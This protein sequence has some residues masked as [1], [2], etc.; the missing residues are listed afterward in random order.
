MKPT[1]Y[2]SLISAIDIDKLPETLRKGHD[3]VIKSTQNL[4]NWT[5]YEQKPA[6][7][8]TIDLYFNKLKQ[9]LKDHKEIT[10]TKTP[11]KSNGSNTNNVFKLLSEIA[12]GLSGYLKKLKKSET[13]AG[14][15]DEQILVHIIFEPLKRA[16]YYAISLREDGE[17]GDDLAVMYDIELNLTTKKVLIDA[18]EHGESVSRNY[19]AG[20]IEKWLQHLIARGLLIDL[21]DSKKS[22]SGRKSSKAPTIEKQNSTQSKKVEHITEEIKFIKRFIGLH[23]KVKSPAN[24][25]SFLKSLQ[26][27]IIQRQIRKTSVFADEIQMIQDKLV[28]AYNGAKG[29][30]KISI[31]EK[32]LPRLVSI[33]G[34]EEVY[35][36][37]RIIKR[38]VGLQ[39]K[40]ALQK[41]LESF[42]KQIE[43][44][45]QSK[46]VADED[47]YYS[48]VKS[49]QTAIKKLKTNDFFKIGKVE[50]NGL[51][52]ILNGCN[53]HKNLGKIYDTEGAE[54]KRCNRGTYSD[55][56]GKGTCSHNR[57]L[58][59]LTSGVLSAEQMAN[60]IVEELNFTYPWDTLL[61]RPATNFSVMFHGDPGSGKT[62]LLL[63][64][65]E[66]LAKNFGRVLYV[67]SEEHGANTLIKKVNAL[68]PVRPSGLD[69]A[70]N[71]N[72]PD[73]SAY[74]FIVLD[75]VN[76]LKLKLDDFNQLKK[77]Y[78]QTSF[79][80]VLQHTKDGNYRGGK[81]WE[82]DI[83]MAVKVEHG[84]ASVYRTRYGVYGTLDFFSHF[85]ITPDMF[86]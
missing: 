11:S 18:A 28:T 76:N 68:L 33:V 17:R 22:S 14:V 4:S 72:D 47:P 6:I 19:E 71:L 55:S 7:K 53:C 44:A 41:N 42:L 43:K 61:G 54:L 30:L 9:Y 60:L 35:P 67:S 52:G 31:N 64:F 1:E 74:D 56:K 65:V 78:P 48:K 23:N 5:L 12:P 34:G 15:L 25:L 51:E 46:K 58:G 62:T 26:R 27:S 83:E 84:I 80:V 10:N 45:L 86:K 2:A 70:G 29:D 73:L 49:I 85:N 24:I 21:R 77:D 32:D 66:Y 39:G 75:S 59:S 40:E 16:G 13:K 8:K 82:H 37:I 79:I 20:E 3:L 69:F 38:Y 63:K 57:G 50:L 81:D 36:S